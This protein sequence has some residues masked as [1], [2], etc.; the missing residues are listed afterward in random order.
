M[1]VGT[2]IFI[3]NTGGAKTK[4]L[5]TNNQANYQADSLPTYKLAEG[6]LFSKKYR[7]NFI[8]H[9]KNKAFATITFKQLRH[10]ALKFTAA[11]KF[12]TVGIFTF[13]L[14]QQRDCT[15]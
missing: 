2:I 6:E 10:S 14:F 3:K 9:K 4:Y 12:F 7:D 8:A 13:L 5:P 1:G 11:V 15:N